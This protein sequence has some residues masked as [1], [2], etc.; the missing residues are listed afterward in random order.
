LEKNNAPKDG[1]QTAFAGPLV[2]GW[3]VR[4]ARRV[5]EE[6]GGEEGEE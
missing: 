2:A 4:K 6:R 1:I 3:V 5:L